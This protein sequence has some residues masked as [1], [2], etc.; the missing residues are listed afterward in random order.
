L[1]HFGTGKR[2]AFFRQRKAYFA[3]KE[4]SLSF[5]RRSFCA[6]SAVLKDGLKMTR[7]LNHS[8]VFANSFV[9][10]FFGTRFALCKSFCGA[11]FKK[12]LAEGS[13]SSPLNFNLFVFQI[14]G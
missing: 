3:D 10:R 7:I 2:F 9:F 12:R 1:R 5:R 11:F 6:S 8:F 4:S 14:R 13:F